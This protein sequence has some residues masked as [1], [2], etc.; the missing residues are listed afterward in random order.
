[1][2]DGIT[3]NQWVEIQTV[4]GKSEKIDRIGK[5]CSFNGPPKITQRRHSV[6]PYSNEEIC[7]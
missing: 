1:M 2:Y 6:V 3:R 4:T 5:F 7:I